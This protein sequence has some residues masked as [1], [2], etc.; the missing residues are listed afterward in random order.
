MIKKIVNHKYII[1]VLI[2]AFG[3]LFSAAGCGN[4]YPEISLKAPDNMDTVTAPTPQYHPQS[5]I[6]FSPEAPY[7][8]M[9]IA[10][11]VTPVQTQENYYKLQTYF[12]EILEQPVELV[13]RSTHAEI[14]QLIRQGLVDTAMVG[15]YSYVELKRAG[16]AE[17]LAVPKRGGQV[18]HHSYIIVPEDSGIESLEDLRDEKFVFTD[19]LS[20][21]GKLYVEYRLQ[22]IGETANTFFSDHIYS[23]SHDNSIIAV[24]EKWVGAASVCSLV[25]DHLVEENPELE[26]KLK[27]IDASPPVGNPPVVVRKNLDSELR[28]KLEEFF[29][30]MHE[31]SRGRDALEEMRIDRFVPGSEADYGPVEQ[32]TTDGEG[33]S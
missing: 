31:S 8:R 5:P 32:M 15:S 11:V 9:A 30:N 20:F 2:T 3:L 7:L 10:P 17:L 27:I 1:L 6:T 21:P 16:Q 26:E 24:A 28:Q 19:S 14:N 29:L 23:Y 33:D 12:L 13:M 18:N 22:E 4:E 25:Y